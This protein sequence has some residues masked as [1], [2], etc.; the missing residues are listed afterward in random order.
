MKIM[1]NKHTGEVK[2]TFK[3]FEEYAD[4]VKLNTKPRPTGYERVDKTKKYYFYT[5]T[6]DVN[7]DVNAGTVIDDCR[8]SCANYFSSIELARLVNR[9]DALMRR[10]RR[11]ISELCEPVNWD[12]YRKI[13]FTIWFNYDNHALEA[14]AY[15]DHRI[16]FGL[17][18]DTRENANK[19]IEEFKDE[20]LW[21]FTEYRERMDA[22]Q[23]IPEET[24][25]PEDDEDYEDCEW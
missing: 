10:V 3:T 18:C 23:P 14:I 19:I 25:E 17:W 21:Y 5:P 24:D 13:K 6:G 11:R 15:R 2:L 22:L 8:Y 9:A 12:E 1:Q 16:L 20:L 7:A 4:Y